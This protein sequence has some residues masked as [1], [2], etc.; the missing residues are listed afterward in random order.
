MMM[1]MISAAYAVMRGSAKIVH[2]C[3]VMNIF[4]IRSKV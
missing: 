3:I 1:M 4:A 2:A